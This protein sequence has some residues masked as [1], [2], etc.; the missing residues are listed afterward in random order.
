MDN[1]TLLQEIK[2]NIL[3]VAEQSSPLGASLWKMFLEVHPADMADFFADIEHE[4]FRLLFLALPR[5]LKVSSFQE[6]PD[7]RKVYILAQLDQE[8]ALA[9][10]SALQA[11][12]LTD[13]FDYFSDQELRTYMNLLNQAVRERVLALMKFHPESAGGI[14]DPQVFTLMQDFTVG[15]SVSILQ[16]LK[17]DKDVYQRIYVTDDN[18]RLLG[19]IDLQD[20]VLHAPQ[21]RISSFMKKNELIV[22]A[23]E[24]RDKVAHQMVHYGLTNAPVV[25]PDGVFLGV[26]PADTLADV[27]VEEAG[28]DVQR[29]SAMTPLKQSYFD[30]PFLKL[31][32]ERSGILII[33]LLVES[34][35]GV[36]LDMYEST[37]GVVLLFFIPMIISTGGNTS[38]QTSAVAIQGMAAGEIRESNMLKFL[39]RELRVGA[40][41]GLLIGIAAFIRVFLTTA[42][43]LYSFSISLTLCLI[44]MLAVALGSLVP[45][46]LKRL[47]IDPAF[48][49][50]PFLATA[51]DILGVLIYCTVSRM[52]LS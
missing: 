33:L 49:A 51:M 36:I 43:Y 7:S 32:Y 50:G 47:N 8:D 24:D 40:G 37:L 42:S 39:K 5:E 46:V 48:S 11:D 19:H 13:L 3:V 4:E 21:E 28:E 2:D 20:L 16:R 23:D 44:V 41:I 25:S 17:P 22:P 45:L 26:V 12:E 18:Q 35:S 30:T 14:M 1:K 52:I 10:L 34:I 29:I 27:L 9:I 15:K 6:L 31:L 38:S